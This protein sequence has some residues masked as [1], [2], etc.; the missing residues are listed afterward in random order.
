MPRI[1]EKVERR[2]GEKLLLKGSRCIGPK[3]AAV[4]RAYPPGF[5]G[6]RS[7]RRRSGSE[8]GQLLREKQ[9]LRYL[10]GLDDREIKR[11]SKEAVSKRGVF[12][13]NL[14]AALERRLD[15]VV[16]RLGFAESRRIARQAVS[17]GHITVNGKMVT[18]PSY[19]VRKGDAAAIKESSLPSGHF[20]DLEA[21]LKKFE[22]P[23]WLHLDKNKK[24]GTV[25]EIPDVSD[26]ALAVDVTKVK[27]YY[28]R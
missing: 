13:A 28:S 9:K 15:N 5:H 1:L 7:E 18:I 8:F 19:L 22:P 11:Y 21:R 23:R 17:H 3:C 2:L 25:A 20:A 4:R 27:E 6:K 26:M 24:T 10:Y 16:F 12:T 14:I